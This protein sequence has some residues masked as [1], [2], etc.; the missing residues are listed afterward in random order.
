MKY[1]F[2]TLFDSSYLSRGLALYYS[3]KSN[4]NDF[5]LYIFA[6]DANS[7]K[8]L[9]GLNLNRAT[10][11]SQSAF[12]DDRL[13]YVKPK[14]TRAEYCWTSTSSS[15]LYCLN[16]YKIDHCTYLDADI[17]FFSSPKFIFDEIGESSIAIT[18]HHYTKRYDQSSTSGKYCVQ[19]IFFKNDE[20]GIKAL[21]WWRESC[22]DW[23]YAR[24]ENGKF[25]DQK[26]LDD[27]TVRFNNVHV[28]KNIGA[29]VAPWNVQQYKFPDK[30]NDTFF[31]LD[32]AQNESFQLIFYHFHG[33]HFTIKDGCV[34][35]DPSKFELS[36]NV[37]Q[38]IYI[39]YINRLID[40]EDSINAFKRIS[41]NEY[42]FK[43]N[44]LIRKFYLSIRLFFKKYRLFQT[45]NRF[46]I[47]SSR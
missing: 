42:V 28:I 45:I 11:I 31:L 13:L 18:E 12:E 34:E 39:P 32:N 26:Y 23:C 10:I 9:S 25:G 33:L 22:I 30:G 37:Q 27:W 8:I 41:K 44:S 15:I 16:K 24:L 35:V 38:L 46:F 36:V 2:C 1:S 5:H 6:F 4:C 20:E 21:R 47:K 7:Y 14:R 29:G 19:F 43:K 3:L 17:Y 40:I